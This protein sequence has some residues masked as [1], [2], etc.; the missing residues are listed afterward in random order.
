MLFNSTIFLAVFLPIVLAGFFVLA[1]T[2]RRYWAGIWLTLAS[3]FFYG[4]WD[5]RYLPL[6]LASM[7]F[8]YTA[9]RYLARQPVK[10]VLVGAIAVNVLLLGYFKYTEF[11]AGALN[12]ALGLDWTLSHIVLPLAISFFTFQQ[13]AYVCDA[14]DGVAVEHDFANYCLFI[15]FFPHLIAGPITHHK[16]M[17]PQFNDPKNFRPRWDFISIGATLFLIGLFKKV[18]IADRFGT[19][20]APVFVAAADDI[21][22]GLVDAWGGALAYTL[23]LYFDFSGYTDMAIG[24]GIMFCIRLPQNFNSPYKAGSIIEFWSRWHMTL[25]RFLTA[26]VYNPIVVSMTRARAV[27]GLPLPRRGRMSLGAWLSLVVYPTLLTLFVSGVWHGAGWQFIIFGLLHGFYLCVNHGWRAVKAKYK[28]ADSNHP[29]LIGCTVL[30][31]FA[32]VVVSLMFFRASS[33]PAAMNML[34]GMA[35]AGGAAAS[36]PD[37]VTL[38]R[39]L[40][41]QVGLA[42]SPVSYMTTTQLSWIVVMLAAVWTLPNAQQWLH[43]YP[44]ALQP[45]PQPNWLQRIAPALTWRPTTTSGVLIGWFGF[46]VVMRALS[47]APT[48]FLYFQ[49]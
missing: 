45:Q 1:G 48:E 6:L 49:F 28:L 7:A 22:L 25:T 5:V 11:F 10:A 37:E 18:E 40:M 3:L 12:Q 41:E 19:V 32:C 31:T 39:L 44:T 14:Y 42:I 24:L 16:E 23:Q 38:R 13:I 46:F 4:W 43:R 21:P 26:Y 34:S 15:T 30:L 36:L 17:L 20:A 8:N 35:G 27:K 47:L 2:G 29:A 33:V 9:G